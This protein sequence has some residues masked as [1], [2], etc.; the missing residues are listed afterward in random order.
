MSVAVL[1]LIRGA[2][3]DKIKWINYEALIT[4]K[5]GGKNPVTM[6]MTFD[7]IPSFAMGLPKTHRIQAENLTQPY[8][9]VVKLFNKYG[10]AFK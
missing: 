4:I 2:N 8:S 10:F 9:K 7:S 1:F 3:N 6:E 5:D